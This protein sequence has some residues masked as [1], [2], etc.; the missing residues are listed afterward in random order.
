MVFSLGPIGSFE[1]FAGITALF[2]FIL[3]SSFNQYPLQA[4]LF[5][6]AGVVPRQAALSRA[7]LD[8]IPPTTNSEQPP[9]PSSIARARHGKSHEPLPP[10]TLRQSELHNRN[11]TVTRTQ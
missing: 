1:P 11:W 9:V 5:S 3:H 6:M 10:L 2:S 7:R 8:L 4:L